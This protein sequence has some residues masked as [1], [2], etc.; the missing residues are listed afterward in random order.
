MISVYLN[1]LGGFYEELDRE[2][3]KSKKENLGKLKKSKKKQILED[4]DK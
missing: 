2:I 1:E 3:L 4:L